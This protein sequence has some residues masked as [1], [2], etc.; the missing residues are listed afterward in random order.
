MNIFTR[1]HAL[2]RPAGDSGYMYISCIHTVF[3][4]HITGTYII[5]YEVELFHS[6]I[7]M[8]FGGYTYYIA[9]EFSQICGVSA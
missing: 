4:C 7:I 9:L 1:K 6:D 2:C 5:Y 3:I 8:S